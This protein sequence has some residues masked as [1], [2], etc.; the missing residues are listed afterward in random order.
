MR[1]LRFSLAE[2]ERQKITKQQK[3]E[4]L[5]MYQKLADNLKKKA[6]GYPKNSSEYKY[7][8]QMERLLRDGIGKIRADLDSRIRADVQAMAEAIVKENNKIWKKYGLLIDGNITSLSTDIVE[9]IISGQLYQADWSLSQA[10]W[11]SS[12]K[13][14]KTIQDIIA[15]GVAGNQS[16]FEIAQNLEQ[17]V[18]PD[19]AKP[20]REIHYVDRNGRKQKFYFGQVDYNAQRL[21]RTMISHA[22]QEAFVRVNRK[23]PFVKKFRWDASN[24]RP[25][26]LCRQRDGKLFAKDRLPLDHPN[27][28]CT[29]EAVIEASDAEINKRIAAWYRG[30]P[31]RELEAYMRDIG[32]RHQI[33]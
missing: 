23:N 18:R 2:R 16:A 4:I 14:Q 3:K 33:P 13:I 24:S 29:F 25:C 11:G 10:L 32:A 7:T 5:A 27:G 9:T 1:T 21:A 30:T 12:R 31:D 28:M 6:A 17:Y 15:A 8:K 20:S 19:A 26:P 22:Y